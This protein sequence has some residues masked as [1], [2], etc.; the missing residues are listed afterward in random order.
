MIYNIYYN[1]LNKELKKAINS[2]SISVEDLKKVYENLKM[3]NSK[4]KK[5][6]NL[7]MIIVIVIFGILGIPTFINSGNP[8]FTKFMLLFLIPIIIVIYGIVYFTQIGL[9]K[10]QFNNAIKKNYPELVDDLKL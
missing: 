5:T 6:I 10:I 2:K 7:I 1:T 3:K 4:K 8:E 9:I